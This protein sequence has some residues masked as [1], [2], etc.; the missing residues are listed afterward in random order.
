LP[1][2]PNQKSSTP[3]SV[4]VIDSEEGP[5][6]ALEGALS[7]QG[8]Q[9]KGSGDT[10]EALKMAGVGPLHAIILGDK[11]AQLDAPLV[12]RRLFEGRVSASV[13]VTGVAQTT[14][15][16]IIESLR[17][18]AVEF[19]RKPLQ[20]A[21]VMDAV[22][23]AVTIARK[24]Q[25]EPAAATPTF[26]ESVVPRKPTPLHP[27]L[28]AIFDKLRDAPVEIPTSPMILGELR[29]AMNQSRTSL[30][31]VARLVQY[32]PS[33][34]LELL[35][36]AN[37]QAY[38]RGTRTSD[39]KTAVGRVGLKPLET[40]VEAV[41]QRGC[42]VPASPAFREMLSS[43][44]WYSAASALAMRVL[45]ELLG[46]S[47]RLDPG[48]AYA[49]GLFRDLGAAFLIRLV[50]ER[51]PSVEAAD[52]LLFIRQRH[53]YAASLLLSGLGLDPAIAQV[54]SS[55]HA[56]SAPTGSSLYWPLSAMA[57]ELADTALPGGDVTR[58]VRRGAAFT[59]T[60]ADT[61][62]ISEGLL[63]KATDQLAVELA[64]V[65]VLFG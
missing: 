19:V 17:A 12:L 45:A 11:L 13:V 56:Q 61:L 8:Y 14:T 22:H 49:A 4:L 34:S 20:P 18:G 25:S 47:A 55:H 28:A 44:W 35:K 5:R 32:D 16:R 1:A 40:V 37:S 27:A 21:I 2:T 43:L 62:R 26:P 31:D 46:P 59:A 52:Y 48:V 41:F 65:S 7:R 24:K 39:I 54:A 29:K 50:S 30:D 64:S 60:S 9:V 57:T 53:E 36:L 42:F 33:I 23:R 6:K 3:D 58:L 63:R 51:A 38:A 15:E 10:E